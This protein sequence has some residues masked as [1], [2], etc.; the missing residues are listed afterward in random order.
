MPPQLAVVLPRLKSKDIPN[1]F[2]RQSDDVRHRALDLFDD[3]S[4][5]VLRRVG[6][7]FVQGMD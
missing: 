7:G 1:P 6:T 2:H 4:V 5:V 3:A